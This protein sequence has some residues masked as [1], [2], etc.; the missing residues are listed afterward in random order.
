[1]GQPDEPGSGSSSGKRRGGGRAKKSQRSNIRHRA[2]DSDFGILVS[3]LKSLELVMDLVHLDRFAES[4]KSLIQTVAEIPVLSLDSFPALGGQYCKLNELCSRILSKVL[5]PGHG[6][7]AE[8][9]A[10]VL[11]SLCPIILSGKSPARNFALTFVKDTMMRLAE[12]SDGV[13]KALTNLPRYLA[14]KAPEKAEPRALAVESI[15]EIV[16]MMEHTAQIEIV[17]YV[18]K[19]TQGKSNLRL[20]GVDLLVNL[21]ISLGATLQEDGNSTDMEMRNLWLVNSLRALLNRCSDS[22]SIIRA[23]ALSNL[24]QLIEHF[25]GNGRNVR[26]F[27]E[28]LGVGDGQRGGINELLQKRCVDE[29][30][31]VRRSAI[32]LVTKLTAL[33]GGSFDA[34]VLKTLGM[35][36]SDPLVSIRKAAVLALSEVR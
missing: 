35:A 33:M 19:M 6:E 29:K 11:K 4:L 10:E 18:V 5:S 28:V 12:E 34:N 13:Q 1:M 20:L 32:N 14:H 9:A 2:D 36:C 16:R 30:A 15:M 21:M 25:L 8:S 3:V 22:N 26:M 17:E 7:V 27:K 24:A 23:R 31:A